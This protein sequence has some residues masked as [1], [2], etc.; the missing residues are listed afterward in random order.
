MGNSLTKSCSDHRYGSIAYVDRDIRLTT[1]IAVCWYDKNEGRV[2]VDHQY[3]CT[4]FPRGKL[5]TCSKTVEKR[6][7]RWRANNFGEIEVMLERA[8]GKDISL[9]FTQ[10]G[11]LFYYLGETRQMLATDRHLRD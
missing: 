11:D 4:R 1:E 2:T 9:Q 10:D 5:D 7:N 6:V 3:V 8:L